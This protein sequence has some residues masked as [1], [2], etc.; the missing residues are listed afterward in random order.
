MDNLQLY[1]GYSTQEIQ[2]LLQEKVKVLKYLM[3]FNLMSVDE[4][5][6]AMAEYYTNHDEFMRSVTTHKPH[7]DKHR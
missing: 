6:D 7:G 3:N 2:K 1:T 4:V 5:G